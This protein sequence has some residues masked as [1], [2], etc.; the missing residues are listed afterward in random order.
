VTPKITITVGHRI[1]RYLILPNWEIRAMTICD[2]DKLCAR[3]RPIW[4]GL[5]VD[6]DRTLRAGNHPETTR[7]NYLLA[8]RNSR[9]IWMTNL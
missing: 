2:I 5:L 7:Y 9:C 4:A 6:W 3:L 8:A 1:D